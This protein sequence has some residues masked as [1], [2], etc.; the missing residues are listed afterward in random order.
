MYLVAYRNTEASARP[1]PIIDDG[2]VTRSIEQIRLEKA[3]ERR[4]AEYALHAEEREREQLLLAEKVAEAER[5][6]QERI[7]AHKANDEALFRHTYDDIERRAIK[8]FNVTRREINS[9]RRMRE[10][11]FVRQFIIYWCARL[12]RLS[13]PQI[14]RRMGGRDHTTAL[15][16]KSMY[17]RKRKAMG[18]T[19]REAR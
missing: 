16:G 17:V 6:R 5:Q 9:E 14:G 13:Y 15:H 2:W 7:A 3:E 8:L 1:K 11:V 18:R 12:T 19:L 10:I 4:R